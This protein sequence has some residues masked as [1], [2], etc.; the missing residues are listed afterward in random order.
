MSGLE[1]NEPKPKK[2]KA[3][4]L[5]R[6]SKNKESSFN[7]FQKFEFVRKTR[8]SSSER[9]R[10]HDINFNGKL[11]VLQGPELITKRA[12]GKKRGKQNVKFSL[13]LERTD[14]AA[15]DGPGSPT[16]RKNPNHPAIKLPPGRESLPKP[17]PVKIEET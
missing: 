15:V 12:K 17:R 5:G 1:F 2:T 8:L 11:K 6:K 16:I 9:E 3:P 13:S 4:K 7:S 14:M 10:E